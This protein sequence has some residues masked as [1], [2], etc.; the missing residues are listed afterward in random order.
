MYVQYATKYYMVYRA[1]L[2]IHLEFQ[3]W[4][5]VNRSRQLFHIRKQTVEVVPKFVIVY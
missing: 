3:S 4:L 5:N 2:H 1:R